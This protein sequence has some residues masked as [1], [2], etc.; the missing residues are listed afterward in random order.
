MTNPHTEITGFHH[1]YDLYF[2]PC[3]KNRN[4]FKM[5]V[6]FRQM[7]SLDS[8]HAE[9]L[10]GSTHLEDIHLS[11]GCLRAFWNPKLNDF[12]FQSLF[13]SDPGKCDGYLLHSTYYHI[14][15]SNSMPVISWISSPGLRA[16]NQAT[17]SQSQSVSQVI[18][19]PQTQKSWRFS[20]AKMMRIELLR[21]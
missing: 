18:Y 21:C 20:S 1:V 3:P 11:D 6:C 4:L 13:Q 5:R 19:T 10:L 12:K 15:P 7:Q 14:I 9:S 8:F 17:S 16:L 2:D